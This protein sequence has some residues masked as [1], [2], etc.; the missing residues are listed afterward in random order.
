MS[1]GDAKISAIQ[2][3]LV[4]NGFN[5]GEIDGVWGRRS[6]AAARAF[7]RARGL[8][9]DGVV[10]PE[11][12]AALFPKDDQPFTDAPLVWFEEAKNLIGTKEI[13]GRGSNKEIIKWAEKLN[14]DYKDDDIPWCGLFAAHC[15]GATL[16]NEPL[17]PNPL[18]ARNWQ[19]FGESTSPRLGAVLVFWREA[20]NGSKGHVGFYYAEDKEAFTVLGGNQSNSVSL[21]RVAKTRLLAA[22]WPKSAGLISSRVVERDF[23]KPLSHDES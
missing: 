5:P 22:R 15:V 16:P 18:G 9:P 2:K 20:K 12:L 8:T 4:A 19:S 3:A 17:P 21:A 10:G 11:T 14:I 7:Q 1:K 6:D 23:D 13:S